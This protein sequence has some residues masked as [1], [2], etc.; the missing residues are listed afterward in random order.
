MDSCC[1]G[2]ENTKISDTSHNIL[3]IKACLYVHSDNINQNVSLHE[4][5]D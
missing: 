5:S 2:K 1:I 3:A 4:I